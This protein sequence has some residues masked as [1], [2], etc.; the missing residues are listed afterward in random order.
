MKFPEWQQF[1]TALDALQDDKVV[2]H[3]RTQN[4]KNADLIFSMLPSPFDVL[5]KAIYGDKKGSKLLRLKRLLDYLAFLKSQGPV[6]YQKVTR[7]LEDVSSPSVE[8]IRDVLI[9]S[10]DE[11]IAGRLNQTSERRQSSSVSTSSPAKYGTG[12]GVSNSRLS[13]YAQAPRKE[14]TRYNLR[15][16]YNSL[17]RLPSRSPPVFDRGRMTRNQYSPLPPPPRPPRGGNISGAYGT[18]RGPTLGS[19]K[20]DSKTKQ[21]IVRYPYA[22]FPALVAVEKTANLSIIVKATRP[23]K[24]S[25]QNISEDAV[26]TT[27]RTNRN[28]NAEVLA[29]LDHKSISECFKNESRTFSKIITVPRK[30]QDSKAVQFILRGKKEGTCKIQVRI[31]QNGDPKGRLVLPTSVTASS[32][33]GLD[34]KLVIDSP[35]DVQLSSDRVLQNYIRGIYSIYISETEK[36]NEYQVD[37]SSDDGDAR[38]FSEKIKLRRQDPEREFNYYFKVIENKNKIPPLLKENLESIGSNLYQ[39]L[40]PHDLRQYYRG[41]REKIKRI[42]VYTEDTWIPWEAIRPWGEV[43]GGTPFPTDFLCTQYLFSRWYFSRE[44]RDGSIIPLD[45]LVK[46][47]KVIAPKDAKIKTIRREANWIYSEF[48]RGDKIKVFRASNFQEVMKTLRKEYTDE[49]TEKEGYDLLHFCSHGSYD[50]DSPSFSYFELEK[51]NHDFTPSKI[52]DTATRFGRH[53]PIVIMNSC[54][55]AQVGNSLAGIQGWAD[56]FLDAGASAFIGARWQI[57]AKIAF[58]FTQALYGYLRSGNMLLEDA[59]RK[60]RNAVREKYPEE[61]AWLA[62]V[63]YGKPDLQVRFNI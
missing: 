26:R 63:Y 7:K 61:N 60:S 4:P 56:A 1:L 15:G 2:Q 8:L 6:H 46:K 48:D 29:V 57:D 13:Q 54:E 41:H 28:R 20:R 27:L 42:R 62:Y 55:S 58:E 5:A 25:G 44:G 9:I 22:T 14:V 30:L 38:K 33:R 18:T 12:T 24:S 51:E 19:A 35:Q 43:D 40:F 34:K 17:H 52:V 10:S 37:V 23:P 36:S 50:R 53:H 45:R 59:V 16:S 11:M 47:I 49:V 21:Q 32:R 31:L 3:I 39:D